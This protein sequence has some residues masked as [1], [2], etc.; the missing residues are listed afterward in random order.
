MSE[1]RCTK[2]ATHKLR[3]PL[4]TN[5]DCF[6]GDGV[7]ICSH[8]L[9]CLFDIPA[10]AEAIWVTI[11]ARATTS[12]M[13]MTI[14]YRGGCWTLSAEN[15]LSWMRSRMWYSL[16]RYLRRFGVPSVFYVEVEYL[17]PNSP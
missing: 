13:R 14:A 15:G 16:E 12:T 10:D 1:R 2:T 9:R 6:I 5:P 3:R 8:A 7:K 11:R 17:D 4:W